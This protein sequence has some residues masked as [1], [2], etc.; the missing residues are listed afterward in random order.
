M[1]WVIIDLFGEEPTEKTE[2]DNK[3]KL[4]P[5]RDQ[6]DR[7]LKKQVININGQVVTI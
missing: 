2:T 3:V 4:E 6:K 7:R 1:S 5:K